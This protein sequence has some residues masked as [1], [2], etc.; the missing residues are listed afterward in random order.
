MATIAMKMT[1]WAKEHSL[2]ADRAVILALLRFS[3]LECP[4]TL[5]NGGDTSN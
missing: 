5:V 1:P 3:G 4:V 2:D